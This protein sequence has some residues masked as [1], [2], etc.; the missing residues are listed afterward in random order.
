MR[1]KFMD[2]FYNLL[3]IN[4]LGLLYDVIKWTHFGEFDSLQE[5]LGKNYQKEVING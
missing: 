5:N 2:S 3:C 4:D 1:N